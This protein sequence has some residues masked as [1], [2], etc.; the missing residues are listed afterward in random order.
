M[1]ET[2]LDIKKLKSRT[3]Q[4]KGI[5]KAGNVRCEMVFF[6]CFPGKGNNKTLIG[7]IVWI[8]LTQWGTYS[9]ERDRDSTA[10]TSRDVTPDSLTKQ[11]RQKDSIDLNGHRKVSWEQ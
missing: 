7:K 8:F 11:S 1:D 4:E 9:S 5:L 10:M 3:F 2:H 6:S